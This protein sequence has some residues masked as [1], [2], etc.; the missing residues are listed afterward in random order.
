MRNEQGGESVRSTVDGVV[1]FA[2]EF[3]LVRG[4][5][6]KHVQ[7]RLCVPDQTH[8]KFEY[9]GQHWKGLGY[10][11]RLI[12]EYHNGPLAGHIGRERTYELM[13]KDY[14]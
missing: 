12:L 6:F 3:E 9:P 8:S 4:L 1:E 14:W 5:L 13:A 10:R 2:K 11:E 7:L